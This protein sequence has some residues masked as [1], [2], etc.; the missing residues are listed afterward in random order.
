M[1]IERLLSKP[2][3]S[4]PPTASCTEAAR[5]MR[6]ENIG[7]VVVM[8]DGAPV[9][10]VTDRDLTLRVLAEE[11]DPANVTVGDV[12]TRFPA[13]LSIERDL[14]EALRTM[15]EMG[16]RRLPV[17]DA[18][19]Q[20]AGMLSLD[21]ALIELGTQLEQVRKLLLSEGRPPHGESSRSQGA[22][23]SSAAS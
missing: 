21:D 13:F 20:I 5:R 22:A 1:S 11:L 12:M 8:Q 16:V 19:G 15:R 14:G 4:L 6:R 17:N 7:C 10:I 2:V 9:G 18:S 23:A 3:S